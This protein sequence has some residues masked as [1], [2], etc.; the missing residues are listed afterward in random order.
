MLMLL[1]LGSVCPV[2]FSEVPGVV[3]LGMFLLNSYNFSPEPSQALGR[4]ATTECFFSLFNRE[5]RFT[6][7]PPCRFA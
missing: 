4:P 6:L 3:L 5:C 2:I 1:C 7:S